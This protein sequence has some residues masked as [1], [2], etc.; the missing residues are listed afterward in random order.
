[1]D[2]RISDEELWKDIQRV[3][4]ATTGEIRKTDID[5]YGEYSYA[6]IRRRFG[7]MN[8]VRKELG[9]SEYNGRRRINELNEEIFESWTSTSAYII[10]FFLAD[11]HLDSE[12]YGVR[13]TSEYRSHLE[14]IKTGLGTEAEVK[15]RAERD[16]YYLQVYSKVLF[17]YFRTHGISGKKAYSA[18]VSWEIPEKV[19]NHF[20]RG[21]FD[22]DG[23]IAPNQGYP[24]VDFGSMSE[25]LIED[26]KKLLE[27]EGYEP[28]Y[29]QR[30]DGYTQIRIF[31][32]Q[33]EDFY[34]YIYPNDEV[35]KLEPK[36]RRFSNLIS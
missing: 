21:Y 6:T 36:Y 4:R 20:I 9:Y 8:E 2:K 24:Q 28:T 10:G 7:G 5:E 35:L 12:N 15:H 18:T 1:M 32:N 17:D 33:A 25:D 13:F 16:S 30:E 11:G 3:D 34:E 23:G 22:G 29:Y 31:G 14:K 26:I 19:R 27:A